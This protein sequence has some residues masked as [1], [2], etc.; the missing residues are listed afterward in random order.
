MFRRF[1]TRQIARSNSSRLFRN[2]S[3]PVRI[4]KNSRSFKPA[5]ASLSAS[6][7][8]GS[9][10]ADNKELKIAIDP[11]F[12]KKVKERKLCRDAVKNFFEDRLK[13]RNMFYSPL[14]KDITTYASKI[15]IEQNRPFEQV[16]AEICKMSASEVTNLISS[17]GTSTLKNLTVKELE[18]VLFQNKCRI[19]YVKNYK[20]MFDSYTSDLQNQL[21]LSKILNNLVWETEQYQNRL[22]IILKERKET[23]DIHNILLRQY[24]LVNE[25]INPK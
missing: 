19:I 15:A 14:H 21:G 4:I 22:Q 8:T 24:Q 12:Y 18:D 3:R 23:D 9:V 2:I 6:L 16:E 10:M 25:L 17:L 11:D 5:I 13:G 1:I 20:C 7:L